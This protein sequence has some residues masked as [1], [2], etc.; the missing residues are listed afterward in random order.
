VVEVPGAGTCLRKMPPRYTLYAPTPEPPSVE[1]LQLRP[2][3]PQL[4]AH[5]LSPLG[6]EGALV[7]FRV[8]AL[9]VFE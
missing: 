6:T 9:A 2:I 7:S 8:V 4:I 3:S 1:A 5:A